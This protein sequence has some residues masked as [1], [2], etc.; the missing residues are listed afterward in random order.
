MKNHLET[1]FQVRYILDACST[2]EDI[3]KAI[4]KHVIAY[5]EKYESAKSFRKITPKKLYQLLEEGN[6]LIVFE[7]YI[8]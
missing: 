4:G 5:N 6:T 3:K 2:D 7:C 1:S 8:I